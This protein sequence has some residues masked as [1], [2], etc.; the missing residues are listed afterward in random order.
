MRVGRW[1]VAHASRSPRAVRGLPAVVGAWRRG[2]TVPE[3]IGSGPTLAEALPADLPLRG[4][5]RRAAGADVAW[6]DEPRRLD[7]LACSLRCGVADAGD[8]APANSVYRWGYLSA[9]T[10]RAVAA[11]SACDRRVLGGGA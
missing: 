11:G 4:T 3:P 5:N 6:P 1:R 2:L 9:R 7:S 10:I 8:R